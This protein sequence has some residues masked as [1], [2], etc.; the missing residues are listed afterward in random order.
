LQGKLEPTRVDLL[1]N[2]K[3]GWKAYHSLELIRAVKRFTS[4]PRW[5]CYKKVIFVACCEIK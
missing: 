1:A 4:E 5:L 3:L 2:I